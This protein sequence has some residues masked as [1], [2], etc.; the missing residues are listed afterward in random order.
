M[1]MSITFGRTSLVPIQAKSL[2]AHALDLVIKRFHFLS[3]LRALGFRRIGGAQF[4]QR[5]LDGEF[6]G[7]GHGKPHIQAKRIR[8]LN[9]LAGGAG[10]RQN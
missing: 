1:K 4:F 6:W 8:A 2:R 5:F 9:N 7:F 10:Y 3:A